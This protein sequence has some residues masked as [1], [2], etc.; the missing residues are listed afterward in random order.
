[1][2]IRA[3]LGRVSNA[4]GL[5]KVDVHNL[6]KPNIQT[7]P[8]AE[9]LI[10]PEADGELLESIKKE[11][12]EQYAHVR[13]DGKKTNAKVS[14]LVY[15]TTTAKTNAVRIGVLLKNEADEPLNI[16]ADFFRPQHGAS[17]MG[18]L[19]RASKDAPVSFVTGTPT[20]KVPPTR[21]SAGVWIFKPN[22]GVQT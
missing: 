10:K 13:E 2:K 22:L 20:C 8:K 14:R 1:M 3:N 15:N 16:P 19:C 6:T 11:F 21:L 9:N 5:S 18:G 7:M 17:S 12:S 4:E